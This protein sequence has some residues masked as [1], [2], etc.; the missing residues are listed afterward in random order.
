MLGWSRL[1]T[2]GGSYPQGAVAGVV[3]QREVPEELAGVVE[4][5]R[6]GRM[7][8]SAEVVSQPIQDG[9]RRAVPGSVYVTTQEFRAA[10]AAVEGVPE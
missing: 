1:E 4:D 3:D 2:F 9:R 7:R 10:F 8:A 5:Y 6:M